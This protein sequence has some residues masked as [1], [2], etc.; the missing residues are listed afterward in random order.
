MLYG[1]LECIEYI[2]FLIRLALHNDYHENEVWSCGRRLIRTTWKQQYVFKESLFKVLFYHVTFNRKL[3]KDGKAL[4][5]TRVVTLSLYLYRSAT[6]CGTISYQWALEN[7]TAVCLWRRLR[8]RK[9][10]KVRTKSKAIKRQGIMFA[11]GEIFFFCLLSLPNNTFVPNSGD[12]M[13]RLK[14]RNQKCLGCSDSV[15][16]FIFWR[17]KQSFSSISQ[18][19]R[20]TLFCKPHKA[21]VLCEDHNYW[22]PCVKIL[23][24]AGSVSGITLLEKG[25]W[26][27]WFEQIVKLVYEQTKKN[28]TKNN[29]HTH[30]HT[31]KLYQR[32]IEQ[33]RQTLAFCYLR[34][35]LE[36]HIDSKSIVLFCLLCSYWKKSLNCCQKQTKRT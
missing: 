24:F 27:P 21:S 2:L 17:H 13:L 25:G 36:F 29:I 11:R 28:N 26:S 34:F 33:W 23:C 4:S 7:T 16:V 10:Q 12:Q 8:K 6:P 31:G 1:L 18:E 19:T 22:H 30:T 3:E 15:S 35:Y 14:K 32:C 5:M 20:R 9:G